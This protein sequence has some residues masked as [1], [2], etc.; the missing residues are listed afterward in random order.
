MKRRYVYAV[1]LLS[2]FRAIQCS[3]A[4]PTLTTLVAFNSTNGRNPA[5]GLSIDQNG[6]L[7]GTTNHQ[8]DANGLGTLFQL[9]GSSHTTLTTLVSFDGTDGANPYADLVSD[10]MG[11]VF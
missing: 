11:N 9:S 2:G 10:G 4:G 5:G 1:I 8:F 7:Y 6:N 3:A